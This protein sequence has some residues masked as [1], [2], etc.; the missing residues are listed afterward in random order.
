MKNLSMQITFIL[1]NTNHKNNSLRKI[2][3]CRQGK[4]S[5]FKELYA[6]SPL[7]DGELLLTVEV[8]DLRITVN[9]FLMF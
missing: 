4:S 2:I 8:T 3:K 9:C 6:E 5:G 1:G 7:E